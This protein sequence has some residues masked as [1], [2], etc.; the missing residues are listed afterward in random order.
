MTQRM[1][2]EERRELARLADSR[3]GRWQEHAD[4]CGQ[5]SEEQRGCSRGKFLHTL[6]SVTH[7]VATRDQVAAARTE[8][9][10]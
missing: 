10:Q 4:D 5:C 9:G 6:W 8:A 3:K 2:E 1:P 7:S